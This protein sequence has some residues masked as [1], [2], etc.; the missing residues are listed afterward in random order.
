MDT[1]IQSVSIGWRTETALLW[2]I[3]VISCVQDDINLKGSGH[4]V[5]TDRPGPA[6]QMIANFIWNKANYST[7]TGI[8]LTPKKPF[9]QQS[10]SSSSPA[11][12]TT[13]SSKDPLLIASYLITFAVCFIY[14]ATTKM[15]V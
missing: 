12:T 6:L 9:D 13:T 14:L 5:G 8:D 10:S 1:T 3:Y 15:L 4:I 2:H 11:P 7:P